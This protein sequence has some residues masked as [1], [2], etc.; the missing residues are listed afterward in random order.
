MYSIKYNTN[1]INFIN[2]IK[3]KEEVII[4]Y[5]VY[6]KMGK[7]E[8]ES[9]LFPVV[10]ITW[11]DLIQILDSHAESAFK[12]TTL[13]ISSDV[14]RDISVIEGTCKQLVEKGIKFFLTDRE[15][16][17]NT[18]D[19]LESLVALGVSQVYVTEDL[20][21]NYNLLDMYSKIIIL[22]IYPNVTQSS[23]LFSTIDTSRHWYIRPEGIRKYEDICT[24]EFWD[25]IGDRQQVLYDIYTNHKWEGD[26]GS[27]IVGLH[28][29][30]D[31][32]TLS[33]GFD[34]I[35]STCG[36]LGCMKCTYCPS[37]LAVAEMLEKTPIQI[38]RKEEKD[39]DRAFES[40]VQLSSVSSEERTE[41][42][43]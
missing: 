7:E 25:S 41:A 2:T 33:L 20:C 27:I 14:Y 5:G 40:F 1:L 17:A 12:D 18:P 34:E 29:H 6:I 13:A 38:L 42:D 35:R 19:K 43:L 16:M 24:I 37:H 10:S 36:K 11:A 31:N 21:F 4:P 22:R 26:L 39:E 9:Y 28:K 23:Q 3:H 8:R 15:F 30:V 32:N